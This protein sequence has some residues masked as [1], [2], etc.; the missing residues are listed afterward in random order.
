MEVSILQ[1]QWPPPSAVGGTLLDTLPGKTGFYI[2]HRALVAQV[3]WYRSPQKWTK[4]LL[5]SILKGGPPSS[6]SQFS[7]GVS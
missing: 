1:S 4:G 2:R 5:A 3:G 6:P 7:Q